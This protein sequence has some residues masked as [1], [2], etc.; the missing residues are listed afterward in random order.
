MSS[1]TTPTVR[2]ILHPRSVAVFGASES[3]DKFGGRI[4]HY[5]IRHGFEGRLVPINP[6]HR[7]VFGRPCV[8]RIGA[9]PGPIDVAILAVPPEVLVPMVEECG[10]AGV[11]CCVILTIGF[12]ETDTPEGVAAQA[13]LVELSRRYG[14]RL[15]GP[16]CLGL[17]NPHHHL[18]LTSSVA[19]EVPALIPGAIG[20]ISQS[21]ALMVSIHNRAHASGIGFSACASLGN[22][23][24]LEICDFLEYM[25][26]DPLTR[27]ICLYVE[28]FKDPMRFLRAAES[29]QRARKPV[30]MVKVG[31]TGPGVRAAKSHTASLAG[32]FAV[33]EAACRERGVI[34]TDDPNDGMV[35]AADVLARWGAPRGDGIGVLSPSGGGVSVTAD[36][37]TERGLRLAALHPSTRDRLRGLLLP[38]QVNNP[39]DLGG[40]LSADIIEN[41]GQAMAALAADPD[42]SALMIMLSTTPFF[43]EVTRELAKAAL[44]SG[45]PVVTIV[46]PGSAADRP[47]EVLRQSGCPFYDRLDDGVRIWEI[48]TAYWR[49]LQRPA[50]VPPGDPPRPAG[51]AEALRRAPAGALTEPEAKTLIAAYGIPVTPGRMAATGDEAVAVAGAIGYPVALKAVSRR[52]VHKTEAGAVRLNLADAASVREAFA[53]VA[54]AVRRYD[55]AAVV[56]G[57]LVQAMARAEAEV[58]VGVRRDPQF[59]PVVL[60]GAG[61]ILAELMRDVQ[62]AL[63]PVSVERAR[64]MLRALRVWPVLEG[65]RGRPALDADA[66]AEI[67]S[68]MSWL[69]ADLDGRLVDLEANPVLVRRAGE[70]AVVVDARG[71]TQ[72]GPSDA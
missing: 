26:E 63:A 1:R 20:L 5:L 34:L 7:E 51:A 44:A 58:I 46:M 22:Q 65:L 24:D 59:G 43:A 13:R 18:A 21:G 67:V 42:V 62:I 25:V 28:G 66:V 64:E 54:D 37:L 32:D 2:E 31:R 36:R 15:V 71:A 11:G 3:T 50:I 9:A 10:Q 61:G 40:R 27:A 49:A 30:I 55:P 52:V 45:K 38:P 70:G 14:I 23:A 19:M 72:G 16:N 4:T 29:A 56:E 39:L 41:A 12:A 17:I 6:S 33:I 8:P 69:G 57:C 48:W 53:A 60:V 47:R 35:Q 68:R